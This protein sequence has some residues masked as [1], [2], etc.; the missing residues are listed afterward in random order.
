[1]M[2]ARWAP[3]DICDLSG[4]PAECTTRATD[5]VIV[6]DV[7]IVTELWDLTEIRVPDPAPKA[8]AGP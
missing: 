5:V 1:M 3:S 6:A 4:G 7:V 8:P 2:V